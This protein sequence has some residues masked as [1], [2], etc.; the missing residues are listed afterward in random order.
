MLSFFRS[1]ES[2]AAID[3][4]AAA[5]RLTVYV[6]A[7]ASMEVGLPP[8]PALIRS[9]LDYVLSD[10]GWTEDHDAFHGETTDEGLLRVA[11]TVDALLG[12]D[13]EPALRTCLFG[14]IDPEDLRPG[15]LARSIA[16][17][18]AAMGPSMQLGTTN[19]DLSLERALSEHPRGGD[20]WWTSAKGYVRRTSSR[21]DVAPVRHL[22]G[23]LDSARSR[24][25]IIL[26][27]RDYYT[28]QRSR[29]WQEEWMVEALTD[30][31][32]LFLGASLTDPN[33]LR[34]LHAAA[35]P[36]LRHIAIFRRRSA[37]TEAEARFRA[38]AEQADRLRWARLGV[39]ALFAENLADVAQFVHEVA[40]RTRKRGAYV[41]LTDRLQEWWRAELDRG[42]LFAGDED[43]YRELQR[44]L[45]DE[46]RGLRDDLRTT[47]GRHRVD[48]SNETLAVALWATYPE[49]AGDDQERVV[50][51]AS[52]Y[53]LN[54][55]G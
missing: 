31:S 48:L 8:W 33:L 51:V 32:C 24:G 43:L 35:S 12:G 23:I 37:R 44:G 28:M 13:L 52:R 30:H 22:H 5:P 9:L 26:T 38:R 7:G 10:R 46:L 6:G 4:L 17:L 21:S 34:Y 53:L 47:L 55:S 54:S 20:R 15:P 42:C 11:E 1:T 40:D 16:D 2:G 36:S 18:H 45:H 41:P 50:V 29:R 3:Y 14:N 25:T 27:E 49:A 39:K 19:Y